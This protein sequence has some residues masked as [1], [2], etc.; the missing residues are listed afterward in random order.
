M[1][2][3]RPHPIRFSVEPRDVPLEKAA[4]RLHLTA[5]QF[6]A[7]LSELLQR[8]FPGADPTTGMFDLQAIDKW[9][10][11][12]NP[13][14]FGLTPLPERVEIRLAD[15]MEERFHAAKVRGRNG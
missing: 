15:T 10:E 2:P 11:R 4:R 12:R 13:A 3:P 1:T 8:G 7:A 6:R 9:C 14:L 5:E